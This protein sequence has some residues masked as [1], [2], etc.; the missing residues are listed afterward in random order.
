MGRSR[1]IGLAD[2]QVDHAAALRFQRTGAH[3]DVES[4]FDADAGHSFC[5]LHSRLTFLNI[6][7]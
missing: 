5:E 7:A 6:P 3:Q 4:R 1:E 2:L